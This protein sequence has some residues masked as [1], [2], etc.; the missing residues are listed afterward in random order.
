MKPNLGKALKLYLF[1]ALTLLYAEDFTFT[2]EINNDTPY[3][4]APVL[5]SVDI[6]QTNPDVV[7]FFQFD[8]PP[9]KAYRLKQIHALHDDTMYHTHHHYLYRVYPLKTGSVT[10]DFKLVKRVTNASKVEYSASGDRDDFKKLETKDTPIN[11]KPVILQ[12]KPLPAGT[13]LVGDFTITHHFSNTAAQRYEPIPFQVVIT[14]KGYPPVIKDLLPKIKGVTFF[15]QKPDIQ[16]TVSKEGIIYKVVYDF[17]LSAKQNFTFPEIR[18][19]AFDPQKEKSYTLHIPAQDFNITA[20]DP[21]DLLDSRDEPKAFTTDL[22]WATAFL[23][24]LV[25]FAAGYFSAMTVKWKKKDLEAEEDPIK[26][27]I[28]RCQDEKALLQLL[29]ATDSKRF[30]SV[31]EALEKGLYKKGKMNLKT[32]K[33]QALEKV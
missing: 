29:M 21:A 4:K 9:S 22:S 10:I 5:L 2:A 7:L 28:R 30:V 26:E 13:T 3:L 16:K 20:V 18:L 15:S 33:A 27:K 17:S 32:L 23:G 11:I 24:Y 1:L 6:N 14:G 25:V 19:N 8:I 12:V 31:I